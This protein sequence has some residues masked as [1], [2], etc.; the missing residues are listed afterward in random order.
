M[1]LQDICQ[2]II[3]L[4]ETFNIWL[5]I[6]LFI[7]PAISEF[8]LS[9]PYLME[10][11]WIIIGYQFYT[12]YILIFQLLILLIVVVSGRITGAFTLFHLAKLGSPR[13]IKLYHKL[14]KPLMTE[15]TTSPNFLRRVLQKINISS[16]FSV[17]FGRLIWFKIPLTLTLG[18]RS[19]LKLL[20]LA[21]LLSSLIWDATYI[22]VGVVGGNARLQP[23]WLVVYSLS[24]LTVVYGLFFITQRL[25][26]L[27]R[28]NNGTIGR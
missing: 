2:E 9:I 21:V 24:A 15:N 23:P 16:P 7:L 12:G 25:L 1:N 20:L 18:I 27:K 5:I 3:T 4:S 6:V 14:F 11:I 28:L 10:T 17:A 13:I 26:R 8:G 22:I 19:Q